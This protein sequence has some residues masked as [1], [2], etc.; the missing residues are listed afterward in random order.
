M[1]T[2]LEPSTIGLLHGKRKESP[3]G[4]IRRKKAKSA[5]SIF[6]F[7]LL[8]T[9]MRYTTEKVYTGSISAT[10]ASSVN[11]FGINSIGTNRELSRNLLKTSSFSNAA[12]IERNNFN[13]H[14]SLVHHNFQNTRT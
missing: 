3:I 12:V 5:L 8:Q 7:P 13:Y 6:C 11:F 4:E 14:E 1:R 2:T 10:S 9:K